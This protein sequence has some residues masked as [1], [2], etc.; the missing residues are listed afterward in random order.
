V[1]FALL[2]LIQTIVPISGMDALIAGSSLA[3]V[4]NSSHLIL[5]I[6]NGRL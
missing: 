5:A 1:A 2:P 4:F 3:P 6:M